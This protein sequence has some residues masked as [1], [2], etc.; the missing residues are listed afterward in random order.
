[1]PH[2]SKIRTAHAIFDE[3]TDLAHE[4]RHSEPCL[5]A[6][7]TDDKMIRTALIVDDEPDIG[8]L[9]SALL[10]QSGVASRKA[11][12]LA[13]AREL[14]SKQQ[15]DVIFLDINLPDG[16]GYELIPEI[17]QQLPD[18]RCITIS[19]ADTES[20][21]ALAYGAH[22]FVAKPFTRTQIWQ[23]M[24]LNPGNPAAH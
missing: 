22:A 13:S 21:K 15:F 3:G 11:S 8:I 2:R 7:A 24:G 19:A 18:A 9:L 14:L 16:L 17:R 10:T 5:L 12:T 6:I 20:A 23:S 4:P 1:M